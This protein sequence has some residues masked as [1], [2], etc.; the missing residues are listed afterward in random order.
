MRGVARTHRFGGEHGATT[1]LSSAAHLSRHDNTTWFFVREQARRGERRIVWLLVVAARPA[2]SV[3]RA[4]SVP[5]KTTSS[6][7]CHSGR[8]IGR[9]RRLKRPLPPPHAP[10]GGDRLMLHR[11]GQVP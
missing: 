1:V 2:R 8:T 6:R 11:C 5:V 9:V 3:A 7:S 4:Q 10:G